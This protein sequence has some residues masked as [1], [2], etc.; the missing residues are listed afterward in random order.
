[1][2]AMAQDSMIVKPG[3]DVR[4]AEHVV[5]LLTKYAVRF[6]P[7]DRFTFYSGIV[8]QLAPI[9]AELQAQIL[10]DDE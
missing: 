8:R 9:R 4:A 1:M 5:D 10:G 3:D 6:D 2:L 7:V